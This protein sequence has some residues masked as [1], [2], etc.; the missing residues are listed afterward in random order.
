MIKNKNLNLE[1]KLNKALKKWFALLSK[2]DRRVLN[3]TGQL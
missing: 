3:V 2:V 1:S